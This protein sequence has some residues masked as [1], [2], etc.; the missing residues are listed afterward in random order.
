MINIENNN[1]YKI[2]KID[3][4]ISKNYDDDD[5]DNDDDDYVTNVRFE[6]FA[7]GAQKHFRPKFTEI[8]VGILFLRTDCRLDVFKARPAQF[9][10]S[11]QQS[12]W[13]IGVAS[14]QV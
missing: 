12:A 14:Q 8:Y 10:H 3:L 9:S 6:A 11:Q 4:L 1:C 13:T 2:L 7:R 5:D